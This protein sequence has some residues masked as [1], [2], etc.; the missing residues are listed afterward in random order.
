MLNSLLE[1]S[2]S[3]HISVYRCCSKHDSH[4]SLPSAVHDWPRVQAPL[5]LKDHYFADGMHCLLY[6]NYITQGISAH[7]IYQS[8]VWLIYTGVKA[9][10]MLLSIL[11]YCCVAKRYRYRLQ[12]EVVNER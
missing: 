5:E 8:E 3:D 11:L 9:S 7:F 2:I 1:L 12:D 6:D 10:L 4:H